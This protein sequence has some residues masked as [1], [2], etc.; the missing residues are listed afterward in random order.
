MPLCLIAIAIPHSLWFALTIMSDAL[1]LAS[2]FLFSLLLSTP[3]KKLAGKTCLS[4]SVCSTS[5]IPLKSQLSRVEILFWILSES[6]GWYS[7]PLV[8]SSFCVIDSNFNL[9]FSII[10]LVNHM[11]LQ[12]FFPS[13]FSSPFFLI[14][15]SDSL[16]RSLSLLSFFPSL[17]P[18]VFVSFRIWVEI[19]YPYSYRSIKMRDFILESCNILYLPRNCCI[20][21][22]LSNLCSSDVS[23]CLHYANNIWTICGQFWSY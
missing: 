4:Q 8:N 9:N 12:L 1:P 11:I 17:M 15:L 21:L 3:I 22:L 16:M 19:Q 10:F 13:F 14:S 20:S 6:W 7:V 5:Q 2:C 18:S 23:I